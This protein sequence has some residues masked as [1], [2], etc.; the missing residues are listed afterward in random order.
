MRT[1]KLTLPR[2]R[3]DCDGEGMV[4]GQRLIPVFS[5]GHEDYMVKCALELLP[6]PPAFTVQGHVSPRLIS[7]VMIRQSVRLS[8][9]RARW[10]TVVP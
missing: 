8:A 6:K 10:R 3:C 9:G 7:G 1:Q 5:P 2:D 4:G